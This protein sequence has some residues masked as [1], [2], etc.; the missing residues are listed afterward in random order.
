MNGRRRA[1]AAL[2]L[3]V[4]AC[5]PL[6]VAACSSG[7]NNAGGNAAQAGT[8]SSSGGK[9]TLRLGYFPNL[10]HGT[11]IVGLEKG[12][13]AENLGPSVNLQTA[14]FAAGPA[15][16]EAVF[17]G[18]ID[19]TY[20]GP[21][22][23]VNAYV[24]SKGA[25]VKVIAGA[26]SGGA[27]LVVKPEI[28]GPQDLKGKKVATPQL[29]NTQDVA[30]RN[31]LKSQNLKTDIQGGGDVSVVPQD[32][33]QTLN[34]FRS[35]QIA[36]AWVPE[37]WAT[38]L[39][40]AGGKVLVDERSLWPNG[41]YATTLLMVR[42]EYLKQHPD[43]VDKLLRGHIAANAYISDHSTDAAQTVNDALGKLSG[44]KLSDADLQSAWKNLS[45]MND[46]VASSVKQSAQAAAGLGLLNLNGV[47][48]TGLFQ[49]DRLNAILKSQG[50]PQVTGS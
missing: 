46:P 36:G 16:V 18:A 8:P 6:L 34:A 35:G 50:Q 14:T 30:L 20:V 15:A 42:S 33:A 13:F 10:T 41:Q 4:L 32:N 49:L 26:A 45:F 17:S 9:Q 37:P 1:S 2:P 43:V 7:N 39:V 22:P 29:G 47:D 31:W 12:I 24:Q 3:L 27:Y 23:A 44:S 28:N 38:R 5:L 40:G 19:A 48:L 11:A 25:A 21:N